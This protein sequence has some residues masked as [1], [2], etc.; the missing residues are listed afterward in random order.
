[1]H[2][3]QT[4]GEAT[5]SR[6]VFRRDVTSAVLFVGAMHGVWRLF[7]FIAYRNLG[8]SEIWIGVIATA[9]YYGYIW[10][11]FLNRV[12]A[13]LSLRRGIVAIMLAS[14]CLLI[15]AGWQTAAIPYC[16]LIITVALLHGLYEVQYGTLVRHLYG[17]D[18]RPRLLSRRFLAISATTIGTALLFGAICR[19]SGRHLEAFLL[20]AVPMIAAALVFRGIPTRDDHPME[21]FRAHE[22]LRTVIRDTRLRR[23]LIVLLFYGWIGAGMRPI[24]TVQFERL[25]F[26]EAQVGQLVAF[27]TAGM[28]L[29]LLVVTPRLRFAGGVTNFRLCFGAASLAMLVYLAVACGVPDSWSMPLMAIGGFLFGGSFAVFGIAMQTTGINLAPPGCT[30]LYV[31]AIMI[32]IGVRGMIMPLVSAEVVKLW[33]VR[34]AITVS[35]IVSCGCLVIAMIPGIDGTEPPSDLPRG[36]RSR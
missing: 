24:L 18:E 26:D 1:M 15:V 36:R 4:A 20:A 8:A 14:A 27:G 21:P 17:R 29:A 10:N 12:T 23:V 28:L 3:T 30:T 19:A 31:N 5:S 35:V 9:G 11:L 33:G 13:R 34:T 2:T 25:G 32:V 22:V 6:A 16:L 7:D